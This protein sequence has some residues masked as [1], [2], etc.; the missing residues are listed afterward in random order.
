MRRF[1]IR[2]LETIEDAVQ[3][4]LLKALRVWGYH[5][6]PE[7]PSGWIYTA[8]KNGFM[9]SLRRS[10]W[11]KDHGDR[12]SADMEEFLGK[13]PTWE[14]PEIRGFLQDSE[15]RLLFQCCH[16]AL[17]L[18]TRVAFTLRTLGGFSDAEIA[19]A[20]LSEPE[21]VQR[22][23]QRARK[24][25][26]EFGA[27]A[28]DLESAMDERMES[29]LHSLYLMFNEGYTLREDGDSGLRRE[30]CEE[31]LRLAALL[32]D[33]SS[34]DPNAAGALCAVFHFQLSRFAAR[35]DADGGVVLLEFQDRNLW[36][37]A[38]IQKGLARMKQSAHGENL[39]RYHLEAGIASCHAL[40]SDF[41]GTDWNLIL[42]HYDLLLRLN[43]SPVVALNRV[44]A[45]SMVAGPESALSE[46]D[47]PWSRTLSDYYP[48][49][50]ALGSLH[51]RAG[52]GEK[53]RTAYSQALTLA[54]NPAVR[55]F[56]QEKIS[57]NF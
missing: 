37:A 56:L 2:H 13:S 23:L 31:A 30:L 21:A 3:E 19:R 28:A 42:E 22:R 17:S 39:T 15:L 6:W 35:L 55:K 33:G 1:G 40:A 45:L 47:K 34:P 27:S 7:N 46:L 25:L 11:L 24:T 43:F 32:A 4:A 52:N 20:F 36:D 51:H 9:D 12:V 5:G 50:A 16:P 38:H 18:P 48:Y 10:A 57:E 8:S 49:W 54:K 53:S 14:E 44:L 29:A 26:Q 41:A